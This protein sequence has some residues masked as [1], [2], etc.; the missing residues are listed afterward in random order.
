MKI[1]LAR[2]GDAVNSSGKFHAYEEHPL[3]SDGRTEVYKLAKELKQYDPSVIY[4]DKL[5]RTKES[6]KIISQELNIPIKYNDALLPLNLGKFAGKSIDTHTNALRHYL[7]NP[8]EKIPGG[9]SINDWATN[10]LPFLEQYLKHKS[11]E[12]IIFMTHGRNIILSKAYLDAGNLAPDFDKDTLL[13]SNN[14]KSTEH[15]GYAIIEP[16][17]KFQIITPHKVKAGQS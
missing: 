10:Y 16:P 4:S 15:G 7:S 8:N 2:H 6:A 3:T 9:E 14:N 13:D 12:C 11:K 1:I 17:N 5:A